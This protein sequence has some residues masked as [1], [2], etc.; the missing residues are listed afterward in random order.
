MRPSPHL[1]AG[2]RRRNGVGAALV[3]LAAALVPMTGQAAGAAAAGAAGPAT[4]AAGS[5]AT[6]PTAIQRVLPTPVSLTEQTGTPF[7]LARTSH[8]YVGSTASG[9]VTQVGY[10]L[11]ELLRPAT[12]Y[13]VPVERRAGLGA[14]DAIY[15]R[16]GG[17]DVLGAE[18]YQLTVTQ[19]AVVLRARTA[20]GLFHGTQ[21]LRQLMPPAVESASVR[22]DTAWTV[23]RVHVTDYPRFSMRGA[24]LDVSR[25]FMSVA[26]VKKYIADL[27]PYKLNHLELHLSDDQG[28]RLFINSWPRLATYG[29]ALEVGG[30]PGGYYT[31]ADYAEIVRYAA[32][33]YITIVPEIDTPGHTNAAQASYAALNCDGKAP[34][35]YTGTDVGFSSLCAAT[36]I[37]YRFL[38][39]VI[40]EIAALTPGPYISI[41]GD[42]AHSTSQ[43]DY[44]TLVDRAQATVRK[45]G[46]TPWGWH[47]TA[48]ANPSRHSVSAYWG[49]AGSKADIAL[50]QEAVAKGQRLVLAPADHAYLDMQYSPNFPYGLHWAAYVS[51]TESY[52]WDPASLIHSVHK[53]DVY[54]VLAPVWTETL[55][56]I[57]AV[58]LMAFPRIAGIAEIGWSPASTHDY[59]A[60]S[61]R[62]AAQATRWTLGGVNFY[63]AP[64]V[65]WDRFST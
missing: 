18:G 16:L 22:H 64:D 7:T 59:A 19:H 21:T 52:N 31:Q 2:A 57:S 24:M 30:T 45:Y 46:K 6:T 25:H 23:P 48:S 14:Q 5:A 54:G 13:P 34:P 27:T 38:D 51:V 20:A 43:A 58:E 8:V 36:P 65:P 10:G 61:V 17:A 11:A 1:T 62:L 60:Y 35:R 56:D 28:W 49:T 40:R 41:G 55:P 37:S 4:A 26:E 39:D 9:A 44:V 3:V 12:G 32:A 29:G 15:L 42:E 50:A 33:H 63:R 47:Q 53:P